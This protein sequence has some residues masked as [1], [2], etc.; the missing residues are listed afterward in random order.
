MTHVKA[1]QLTTREVVV[2]LDHANGKS[3]SIACRFLRDV[4]AKNSIT[5]HTRPSSGRVRL[6]S[7]GGRGERSRRLDARVRSPPSGSNSC[8]KRRSK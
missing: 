3:Q 6:A 2:V 1:S 5:N 7:G 4:S 8:P